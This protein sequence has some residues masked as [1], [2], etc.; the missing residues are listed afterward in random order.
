MG[1]A[2]TARAVAKSKLS[3]VALS[4][5]EMYLG[6]I[7]ENNIIVSEDTSIYRTGY[8]EEYFGNVQMLAAHSNLLFNK[9]GDTYL[10]D[11]NGKHYDI[12]EAHNTF[13]IDDSSIVEDP[14]FVD[15]ENDN[16]ELKET[17]P[18][19]KMGFKKIDIS[20]IGAKR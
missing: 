4:R 15:Y 9:K 2:A 13:G 11:I 5:P 10:L 14:Q 20:D 12:K 1:K 19:F 16:Y 3:P 7:C 17:S 8:E 6:L 18:A